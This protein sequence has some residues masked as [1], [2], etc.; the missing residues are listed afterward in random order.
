MR[1]QLLVTV[2]LFVAILLAGYLY[3]DFQRS[4]QSQLYEKTVSLSDEARTIHAAIQELSEVGND[5]V[6]RHINRICATM[7]AGDSPGHTIEVVVDGRKFVS[8][9]TEHLHDHSSPWSELVSGASNTDGGVLVRVGERRKP[10]VARVRRESLAGLGVL[11]GATIF[12]ALI[13]NLL[14]IRLVTR[15]LERTVH[16]V[17]EVGRGKLGT[18]VGVHTNFELTQLADEISLMSQELARRNSDRDAQI[19][20]ARRLQSYLLPT[21]IQRDRIEIAIEFH[22]ADEIAGDFVD[23]LECP[24]GDTLLCVAD[25]VGHGIHAAMGS[26]VLKALLLTVDLDDPSPSAMLGWINQRFCKTSLPEDFASMVLMRVSKD[27]TQMVYASAGHELGYLRHSDGSF[28]DL[29]SSGTILGVDSQAEFDN[30]EF[31][32]HPNDLVVLLSDGIGETFNANRVIL[33]RSAITSV[34][35]NPTK[36]D[37]GAVAKEIVNKAMDHRGDSPAL[38]DMTVLVLTVT[39]QESRTKI[40]ACIDTVHQSPS[41]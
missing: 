24:N 12:G 20:R 8:Q 33:G 29:N 4:V 31:K 17:R 1:T 7:N 3:I 16:A 15:P 28:H 5:A 35:E 36:T 18:T 11:A 39:H 26:A 27:G 32:L 2:N 34:V 21:Q 38:D 25:V 22:P 10:L 23:V 13:L 30:V 6:Q 37:P 41:G 14:L 19:D 40:S 9:A